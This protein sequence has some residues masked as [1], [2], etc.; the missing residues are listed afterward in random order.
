M[1]VKGVAIKTIQEFVKEKFQ[2][3]Y[4]LWIDALPIESRTIIDSRISLTSW[5]PLETALIIPTG[6]I[7]EMFYKDVTKAAYEL[8]VFSSSQA[9]KGV[10]KMLVMV[11]SPSFIVNRASTIMSGYYRP[12]SMEITKRSKDMAILSIVDFPNPSLIV[13]YRILGWIKNT[14]EF[15]KFNSPKVEMLKSMGQGDPTTDYLV[16][17]S[18]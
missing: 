4:N 9:I 17:W 6:K 7:G 12:C 2:N 8:G 1:E 16:K 11:S 3:E 13:D 5:Y 14:M 10:Y 15:S 18:E